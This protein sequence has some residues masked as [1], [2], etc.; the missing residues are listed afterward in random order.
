MQ[1]SCSKSQC[2]SAT[3]GL[4][5]LLTLIAHPYSL[6][7]LNGKSCFPWLFQSWKL[8]NPY[9]YAVNLHSRICACGRFQNK[10]VPC[11]RA[12]AVI[13]C[14]HDPADVPRR[15]VRDFVTVSAFKPTYAT[16][17]PQV[18]I[19]GFQLRG[20]VLFRAA[21]IRNASARPQTAHLTSREQRARFS[22]F[23]RE[24]RYTMPAISLKWYTI[25][26][27][28]QNTPTTTKQYKKMVAKA[29]KG[30]KK[31]KWLVDAALKLLRHSIHRN[32]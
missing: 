7:L 32:N 10:D 17:L 30:E 4:F 26:T 20:G 12:I 14:H 28:V 27:K 31:K 18:E 25:S 9:R 11:G 8:N 24:K 16:P 1:S 3:T 19:A 23:N 6:I 15:F 13:Q 21:V 22:A 29:A 2:D 5:N